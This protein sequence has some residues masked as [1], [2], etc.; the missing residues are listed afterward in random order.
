ML[1][2]SSLLFHWNTDINGELSSDDSD[3][4]L[5]HWHLDINFVRTVDG[6]PPTKASALPLNDSDKKGRGSIVFFN[7][8]TMFQSSET[9]FNTLKEAKA[10]GAS[11]DGQYTKV[12][13]SQFNRGDILSGRLDTP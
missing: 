1:Y 3:V 13:E 2:P 7:Q 8:A 9:G 10:A 12:V 5:V 4:P 11:T 6:Q